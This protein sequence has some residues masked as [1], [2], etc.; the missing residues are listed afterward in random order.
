M[1]IDLSTPVDQIVWG[2]DKCASNEVAGT[3]ATTDA[4]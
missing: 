3:G 4:R 2:Q 1:D